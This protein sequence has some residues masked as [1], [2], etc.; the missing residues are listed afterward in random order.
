MPEVLAQ[1]EDASFVERFAHR[2]ATRDLPPPRPTY[3]PDQAGV[4]ACLAA[5]LP[6][7]FPSLDPRR[8]RTFAQVFYALMAAPRLNLKDLAAATGKARLSLYKALPL[9]KAT[10]LVGSERAGGQHHYFLTRP[11]EDWVLATTR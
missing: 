11:G 9:L 5:A 8:A 6:A 2:V 10:G 7:L 4:E 3:G 1:P